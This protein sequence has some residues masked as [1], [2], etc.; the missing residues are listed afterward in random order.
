MI[1]FLSKALVIEIHDDQIRSYGG[2]L[3][4]LN[5]SLL[6]S[7]LS[8]PLLAVQFLSPSLYDLAAIY[9]YHICKNHA[10]NDGNKR[11]ACASM[12]TFLEYNKLI[13]ISSEDQIKTKILDIERNKMDKQQLAEWLSSNTRKIPL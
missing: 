8:Q 1:R 13:L 7:A 10:F 2:R 6:D 9:G 11:T 5:E 4:I 3:G 12:M